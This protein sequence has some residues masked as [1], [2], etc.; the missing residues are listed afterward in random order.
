[1]P[2]Y[3]RIPGSL[4]DK[5]H[6]PRGCRYVEEVELDRVWRKKRASAERLCRYCYPED[7]AWEQAEA[8]SREHAIALYPRLRG[9][10]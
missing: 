4:K 5:Y 7:Q 8:R 3:Y 1:M 2:V 10:D 6:K 9:E